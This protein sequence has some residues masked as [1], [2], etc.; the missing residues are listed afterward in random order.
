MVPPRSRQWPSLVLFF[1]DGDGTALPVPI[2]V[3][4]DDVPQDL[5]AEAAVVENVRWIL[6]QVLGWLH[7]GAS[8]VIMVT[9]AGAAEP[10]SDDLLWRKRLSEA[11]AGQGARVRLM[12]LATPGGLL[13]L[14][15]G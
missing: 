12:C 11:A 1:L 4:A 10:D 15:A 5:E 14:A 2:V 9:R 3:P 13:P 6:S 8:V 7:P